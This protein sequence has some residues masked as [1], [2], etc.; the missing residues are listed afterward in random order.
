[1]VVTD[2]EDNSHTLGFGRPEPDISHEYTLVVKST[3]GEVN[4]ESNGARTL[5]EYLTKLKTK[6]ENRANSRARYN[7]NN[8]VKTVLDS[9]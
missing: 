4:C 8:L 5:F 7:R 6:L 1:V 2:I 9:L 3:E